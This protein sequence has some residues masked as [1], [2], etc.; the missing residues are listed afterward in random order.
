MKLTLAHHPIAAMRFGDATR[1]DGVGLTIAADDLRRYLMEDDRLEGVDF[2][3]VRPGEA[4]RIGTIFD[5]IEPRAKA[6]GDGADF[7]GI[8]GPMQTAGTGTTHVLRGAAVTVLDEA[9]PVGGGGGGAAAG[10][11]IIE[12]VG[13]AAAEC[14]YSTLHHLIV[15]PRV[16]KSNDT[17]LVFNVNRSAS[18][19]TVMRLVSVKAAAYLARA[20][21]GQTPA[22]IEVLETAAPGTPGREGLPRFAFIGQVHS[23]QRPA[24][25]DE[26]ILYGANTTGMVPVVLHP[27]EWLD[28]AVV[29]A[30]SSLAGVETYYYQNHPVISELYRWH[31]EGKI[32]FAG[33]VATTAGANNEDRPRSAM[34]AAQQAKWAL[35]ADGAVL[36]KIG[37]GAPHADMGLTALRCEELGI[38]TVVQVQD[39]AGDRDFESALLFNYPEVDAIIVVSANDIRWPAAP[40]TRVIA[41]HGAAAESLAGLRELTAGSVCGAA[42]QQGLSH[43]R[44]FVY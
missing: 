14:P 37:G 12:M 20:A 17:S 19:L 8:L 35:Q 22:S 27:N 30:P 6:P 10:G 15:I 41:G 31:N 5:I 28:G 3:L 38:K 36:T 32:T 40:V 25:V 16:R 21:I 23:R 33:T 1:L 29:A 7:P 9:V 39:M 2:E 42:S 24:E 44:G 34:V 26:Q 4:C 18:A 13:P 11:K 43:A